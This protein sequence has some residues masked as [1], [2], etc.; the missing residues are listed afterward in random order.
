MTA[1]PPE[2]NHPNREDIRN[3]SKEFIDDEDSDVDSISSDDSFSEDADDK[4]DK[5]FSLKPTRKASP[6][7]LKRS[8]GI[9]LT[10][11]TSGGSKLLGKRM[12]E[13]IPAPAEKMKKARRVTEGGQIAFNTSLNRPLTTAEF[14][15][16]LPKPTVTMPVK[17]AEKSPAVEG[18]ADVT[19]VQEAARNVQAGRENVNERQVGTSSHEALEFKERETKERTAALKIKI[20]EDGYARGDSQAAIKGWLDLLG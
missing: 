17:W 6:V 15:K 4:E 20:L 7:F 14:A 2:P 3:L 18:A 1:P 16:S 13:A 11:K 10:D 9:S 19:M 8:L 12:S 5:S